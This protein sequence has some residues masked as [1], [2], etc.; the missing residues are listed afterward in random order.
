LQATTLPAEIER[1]PDRPEDDVRSLRRR[2]VFAHLIDLIVGMIL[3]G[4]AA[5]P[6]GILGVLSFGLLFGPLALA[7]ALIPL[8]YHATLVAGA[9]RGTWGHRLA[10]LTIETLE[11][12][13]ASWPQAAVHWALFYISVAFTWGLIL[14]WSFFNPRKRLLHDVLTGM[15]VRRRPDDGAG[16]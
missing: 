8:V 1:I 4:L 11:G 10:G 3:C 14:V 12:A 16:A 9:K 5:I 7:L 2:R 15:M 6:A 13:R